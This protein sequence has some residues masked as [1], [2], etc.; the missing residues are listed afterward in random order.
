[1]RH[2]ERKIDDKLVQNARTDW[3]YRPLGFY[4]KK[5]KLALSDF[6]A[7]NMIDKL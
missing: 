2:R 6:A 3:K 1:M 5:P 7:S 4:K